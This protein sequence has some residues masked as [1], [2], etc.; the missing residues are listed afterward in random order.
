MTLI[1]LDAAMVLFAP[2]AGIGALWL[3]RGWHITLL[4]CGAAILAWGSLLVSDNLATAAAI[5][6]FNRLPNPTDAEMRDLTADGAWKGFI[7]VFGLPFF[8]LYGLIWF[9]LARLGRRLI[10]KQVQDR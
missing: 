7:F 2:L 3:K 10:R 8:L 9:T 5:S 4:I 6:E 1:V